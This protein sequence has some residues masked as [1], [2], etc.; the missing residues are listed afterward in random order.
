[1]NC[2][3]FTDADVLI[4][5]IPSLYAQCLLN[6]TQLLT[7]PRH[8]PLSTELYINKCRKECRLLGCGAV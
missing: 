2:L 6:D 1:M 7:V 4:K 3:E 5:Y 8:Q